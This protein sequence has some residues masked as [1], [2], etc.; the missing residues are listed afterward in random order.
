MVAVKAI[1][2]NVAVG[3]R[4]LVA[5]VYCANGNLRHTIRDS[6]RQSV[7]ERASVQGRVGAQD[8]EDN[9]AKD[10]QQCELWRL[11]TDPAE[12][13]ATESQEDAKNDSRSR[14]EEFAFENDTSKFS[15][16]IGGGRSRRLSDLQRTFEEYLG[17]GPQTCCDSRCTP[18]PSKTHSEHQRS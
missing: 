12:E 1:A 14:I 7:S 11:C 16:W 2:K 6:P 13:E 3:R 5:S 4:K 8:V 17:A 18:C 10:G 9:G 15:V